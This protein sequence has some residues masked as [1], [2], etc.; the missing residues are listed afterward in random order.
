LLNLLGVKNVDEI[1]RIKVDTDYIS[2]LDAR[3]NSIILVKTGVT[4][5][6]KSVIFDGLGK[7]Q[8]ELMKNIVDAVKENLEDSKN[9]DGFNSMK[10]LYNFLQSMNSS[11]E[12]KYI[13]GYIAKETCFED[14]MV[15]AFDEE[16]QFIFESIM[17]TAMTLY[18]NGGTSKSKLAEAHKRYVNKIERKKEEKLSRTMELNRIRIQAM[19]EL[20]VTEVNLQNAALISEK[21]AEIE[22]RKVGG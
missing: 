1:Q 5:E 10:Y 7:K 12:L 15:F 11:S 18:H 3:L 4:N 19:K 14:P 8:R 16:E 13:L 9:E 20:G 21:M 6:D 17:F 2:D 22:T